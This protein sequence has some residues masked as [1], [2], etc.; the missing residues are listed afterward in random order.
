MLGELLSM[1]TSVPALINPV[2][3]LPL[4]LFSA[5]VPHIVKGAILGMTVGYSNITPRQNLDRAAHLSESHKDKPAKI[6]KGVLAMAQRAAAAHANGLEAFSF[7]GVAMLSAI[8]TGV[9]DRSALSSLATLFILSRQLFNLCYI[10][11]TNDAIAGM[12]SLSF[13]VGTACIGLLFHLA[14]EAY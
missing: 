5:F 6:S 10:C 3:S 7:Y 8:A 11:G 14:S 2:T 1:A 4:A 13:M 12:R 9:K